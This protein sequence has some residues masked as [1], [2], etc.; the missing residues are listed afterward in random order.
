MNLENLIK[1]ENILLDIKSRE[2]YEFLHELCD[3]AEY[4]GLIQDKEEFYKVL[5]NRERLGSTGIGK[6]IAIPHGRSDCVKNITIIFAR[7]NDGIEFDSLDGQKAKIFFLLAAPLDVQSKYLQ[8]LANLS[9]LL[10]KEEF[11]EN[12]MKA[13]SPREVIEILKEK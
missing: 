3:F 6:N 11:R 7:H 10:R 5:E 2:K 1:E 9:M 12:I 13:Q 4:R 8:V